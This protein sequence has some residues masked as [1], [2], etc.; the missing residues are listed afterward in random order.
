MKF[1]KLIL[2]TI[3]TLMFATG[4]AMA[5]KG[6]SIGVFGSSGDL[7]ASGHEIEGTG[8]LEKTATSKSA[9]FEYGGIF[10]EA[11]GGSDHISFTVGISHVPGSA[12]CDASTRADT[13]SDSKE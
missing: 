6:V 11:T 10:A 4:S 9:S 13:V 1:Y 3:V 2:T 8:D 5:F 12:S 7:D